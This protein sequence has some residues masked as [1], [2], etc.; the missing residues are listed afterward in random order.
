VKVRRLTI[1]TIVALL[2]LL[3]SAALAAPNIF[4]IP[5]WTLDSG[6]GNSQGGDYTVS[7]TIGQPDAGS[8]MSGGEY[9]VVGGFWGVGTAPSADHY[10]YLP[11]II[12]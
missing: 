1:I 9:T 7:G 8:S 12:R 4:S 2:L 10:I 6:G 3:V 11:V 5:W